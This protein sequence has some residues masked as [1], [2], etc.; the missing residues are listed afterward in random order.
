MPFEPYSSGTV[1]GLDTIRVLRERSPDDP[2]PRDIARNSDP[3]LEVGEKMPANVAAKY[4]EYSK[5]ELEDAM[6]SLLAAEEIKAD[7]TLMK[8]LQ[9]LLDK[10]ITSI[11]SLE[12]LRTVAKNKIIDASKKEEADEPADAEAKEDAA[13]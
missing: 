10:K 2:R 3:T 6:R 5:Y 11:K 9:D 4:K 12:E 7:P 8:A 1:K 13:G